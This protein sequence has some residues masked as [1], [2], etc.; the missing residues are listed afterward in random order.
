MKNQA[1]VLFSKINKTHI[2]MVL[3]LVTLAML[4]LGAGAPSDFGSV[5]R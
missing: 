2:Q 5:G 3:I 1:V 4:V